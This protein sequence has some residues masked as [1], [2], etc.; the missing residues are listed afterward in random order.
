M[1][2]WPSAECQAFSQHVIRAHFN[3]CPCNNQFLFYLRIIRPVS[4]V[5]PFFDI[6][7]W[8]HKSLSILVF[9]A[10]FQ[11]GSSSPV[12]LV[13]SLSKGM[14]KYF[15]SLIALFKAPARFAFTIS[16]SNS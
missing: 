11:S 15:L 14:G 6:S 7:S 9:F 12:P 5:F 8:Y 13:E 16:L 2:I 3:Q 4:S 1:Q 10:T